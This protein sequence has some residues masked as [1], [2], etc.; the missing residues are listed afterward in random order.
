M[1]HEVRTHHWWPEAVS[2]YWTNAD[3][4]IHWLRPDGTVE[5]LLPPSIGVIGNAHAVKLSRDPAQATPWDTSFEEE[6]DR[7]DTQ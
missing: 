2:Q 3:G 1:T 5:P 7:A 6:F 4:G